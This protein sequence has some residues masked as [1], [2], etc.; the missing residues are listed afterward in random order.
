[1]VEAT[2]D[3]PTYSVVIPVYNEAENIMPLYNRLKRVLDALTPPNYEIV[4]VDDGSSDDTFPILDKLHREDKCV[5]VIRFRRNFGQTAAL[6]AGFDFAK[7]DI[8]IVMDGD[9]QNDPEDIPK[10]LD[11]LNDGYDAVSGWR[12]K[13]KDPYWSKRLPSKISNWLARKLTGLTIHDSGCSLKA[14]RRYAIEN[15]TLYGEM[16]RYIPAIIAMDGYKVGEVKVRHHARAHGKTK[17]GGGRLIRGLLDLMYIKFWSKYA[18]RPLHFYGEIGILLMLI[19]LIIAFY[20]VGIELIV[21]REPLEAGPLLL[22]SVLLII[23]G[24]QIFM[25]GFLSEMQ[26][27]AHYSRTGTKTYSVRE[28]LD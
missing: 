19:G 27:R 12:Y 16:H 4:F 23:T 9:L 15:L 11:K 10:L 21:F 6:N 26:I 17:Y 8:I 5:K 14:Y 20:K 22:L 13:R 1:M 3:T 18:S 2:K 28:V 24:I 7:G 25:F